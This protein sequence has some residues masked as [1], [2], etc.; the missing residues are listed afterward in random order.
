MNYA[1]LYEPVLMLGCL[2]SAVLAHAASAKL[3]SSRALAT[4]SK[5]DSGTVQVHGF[6]QWVHKT[7]ASAELAASIAYFGSLASGSYRHAATILG[8]SYVLIWAAG[9]YLYFTGTPCECFGS[10]SNMSRHL[11]VLR[12]T[13]LATS[14][15]GYWIYFA[16]F[17]PNIKMSVSSDM[18][19]MYSAVSIYIFSTV[20]WSVGPSI[21]RWVRNDIRNSPLSGDY[22]DTTLVE[23]P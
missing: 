15:A 12:S 16:G 8:I 1:A 6:P 11:S 2:L 23:V 5:N 17:D 9:V 14:A 22:Q 10:E 20:V 4:M 3:L 21:Y 7:A 19:I 18:W 13:F